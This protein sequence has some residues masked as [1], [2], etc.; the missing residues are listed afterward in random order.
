MQII[1]FLKPYVRVTRIF[2]TFIAPMILMCLYMTH[3]SMRTKKIQKLIRNFKS[4]RTF[5][6]SSS[7]S[8]H[9]NGIMELT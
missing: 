8:S 5:M 2:V 1:E 3:T 9:T 6:G 7:W 4:D